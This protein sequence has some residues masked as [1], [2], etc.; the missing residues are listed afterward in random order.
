MIRTI[1]VMTHTKIEIGQKYSTKKISKNV[2][3]KWVLANQANQLT[4]AWQ[5]NSIINQ[6]NLVYFLKKRISSSNK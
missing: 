2:K 3:Y 5:Y 1:R 4:S 6:F